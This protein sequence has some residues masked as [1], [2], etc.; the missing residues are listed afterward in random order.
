MRLAIILASTLISTTA[1]A[2]EVIHSDHTG[3]HS[4]GDGHIAINHDGHVD[5]LHDGHLHNLHG[6]HVDEHVLPVS[7]ANPVAEEIVSQVADHKHV[8]DAKDKEHQKVQHGDHF[9]FVDG[10]RL[11]F[12]HGDHV[13][14]HG[15]LKFVK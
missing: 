4:A 6:D 11:H 9:D 7:E 14:D 5:H 2:H 8:H 1:F 3:V 10:G 13:D 12:V 15:A